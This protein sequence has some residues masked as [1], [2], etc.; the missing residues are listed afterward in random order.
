MRGKEE[1]RERSQNIRGNNY[2]HAVQFVMGLLRCGF[3]T[4][5][6]SEPLISGYT[7]G[8]AI[9][10]FTSQLQHITGLADVIKVPNGPFK[11]PKVRYSF[12]MYIVFLLFF[13]VV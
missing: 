8:A 3:I 7:T 2:Y 5:F 4:Y 12:F 13:I 10:V 6:L 1:R 9:H 11:I